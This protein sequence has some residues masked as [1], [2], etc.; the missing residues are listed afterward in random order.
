M[1]RHDDGGYSRPPLVR[2]E[3]TGKLVPPEDI[4]EFQGVKVSVEG[5]NLLLRE[6]RGGYNADSDQVFVDVEQLVRPSFWRRLLCSLLDGVIVTFSLAFIMVAAFVGY[7]L[8][9]DQRPDETSP[10]VRFMALIAVPVFILLYDFLFISRYGKTPGKMAGKF[11]VVKTDGSP[12]DKTSALIRALFSNMPVGILV[13]FLPSIEK[14]TDYFTYSYSILTCI[15]L[16]ADT[17]CQRAI[18]DWAAGTRVVMDASLAAAQAD[19]E[20]EYVTARA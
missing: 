16:I 12:V 5:K 1:A 7:Y 8:L 18:H 9:Y 19:E 14:A 15:V 20:E 6:L 2:C 13:F 10:P 3:V 4:V 11:R 17:Q